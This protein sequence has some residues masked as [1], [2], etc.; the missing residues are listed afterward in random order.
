[1]MSL[2]VSVVSAQTG[3]LQSPLDQLK[4]TPTDNALREK[5]IKLAVTTKP[6]LPKDAER[7][8]VR[9]G[10]AFKDAKTVSEYQDAV[11]EFQAA[12]DAAPWYGDA[13][14]NLGVTLDKAG[15]FTDALAALKWA[16]MASPDAKDIETLIYEVEYRNEKVNSPAA[17]QAAEQ[18]ARQ[19]AS[20]AN[21]KRFDG[22]WT[23]D[24]HSKSGLTDHQTFRIS[25]SSL[26]AWTVTK[27]DQID[28]GP[29]SQNNPKFSNFRFEGEALIFNYQQGIAYPDHFDVHLTWEVTATLNESGSELS[30]SYR[31]TPFPTAERE[32]NWKDWHR[33]EPPIPYSDVYKRVR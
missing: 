23:T 28:N 27:W 11:T 2:I 21:A 10:V 29:T 31:P 9:G 4:K 6:A 12:V 14:F 13:Y 8:M 17:K 7:H 32:A 16:Q 18:A 22:E 33:G 5:V 24:F 25:H 19:A 26:T 1:M 15:R 20:E 30:L 3:E